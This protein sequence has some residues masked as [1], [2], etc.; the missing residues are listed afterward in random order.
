MP[1]DGLGN[2]DVVFQERRLAIRATETL[3]LLCHY[4]IL[5]KTKLLLRT[6]TLILVIAPKIKQT[7]KGVESII[8]QQNRKKKDF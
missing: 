4:S 8:N 7:N 6:V 3:D 5:K 2:R 1:H